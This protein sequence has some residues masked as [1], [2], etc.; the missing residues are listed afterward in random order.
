MLNL[1]CSTI[2]ISQQRPEK[3]FHYCNIYLG[4]K[5]TFISLKYPFLNKKDIYQDVLLL[6]LIST[7]FVYS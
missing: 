6:C 7:A 5:N 4:I 3:D 1:Y 2:V